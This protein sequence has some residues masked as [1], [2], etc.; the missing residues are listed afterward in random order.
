MGGPV[1]GALERHPGHDENDSL[2]GKGFR[3]ILNRKEHLCP[4]SLL[5][6]TLG[7]VAPFL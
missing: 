3:A 7:D 5:P 2:P 1:G 4:I 6:S